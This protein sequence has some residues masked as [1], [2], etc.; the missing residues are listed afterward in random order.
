MTA[1]LPPAGGK[2]R[3]EGR[4]EGKVRG[5]EMEEEGERER[6]EER[7]WREGMRREGEGVEKELKGT[8]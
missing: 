7:E 3:K 4:G 8:E 5:D 2:G 6:R 1:F